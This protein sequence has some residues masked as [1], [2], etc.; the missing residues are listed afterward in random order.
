MGRKSDYTRL[1]KNTELN[2]E[3]IL[4]KVNKCNMSVREFSKY[5]EYISEKYAKKD[6]TI[7]EKTLRNQLTKLCEDNDYID[8]ED[9]KSG[10]NK[11]FI[12]KPEIHNI[13]LI[14]ILSNSLDNRK[15]DYNLKLL[16]KQTKKI[17]N[18]LKN[19]LPENELQNI[20]Q[21]PI[22]QSKY[23][24]L[25]LLKL[26]NKILLNMLYTIQ[27]SDIT[28]KPYMLYEFTLSLANA[29]KNFKT[30]SQTAS[31]DK[32]FFDYLETPSG[33]EEQLHNMLLENFFFSNSLEQ[34]LINYFIL[35]VKNITVQ[36]YPNKVINKIE[37]MK[38]LKEHFHMCNN[39]RS[40]N[41]CIEVLNQEILKNKRYNDIINKAQKVLNPN[42]PDEKLILDLIKI[43]AENIL[44]FKNLSKDDYKLINGLIKTA[45]KEYK[46][47]ILNKFS[48]Y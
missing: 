17:E 35:K 15:N 10:K 43:N 25:A 40:F 36:N 1:N 39:E 6:F 31:T 8:I 37:L 23:D 16:H 48:T 29:L 28:I 4:Q 41:E 33:S 44:I 9:L 30:I 22:Y 38:I 7:N 47:E 20:E 21:T 2:I 24:E 42:D 45:Y 14:I 27:N 5:C 3:D 19:F 34:L 46:W 32:L 26:S 12:I 13:L 11:K 18:L